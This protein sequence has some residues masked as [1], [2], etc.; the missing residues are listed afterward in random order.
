MIRIFILALVLISQIATAQYS[1]ELDISTKYKTFSKN[2]TIAI[3]YNDEVYDSTIK[4]MMAKHWTLSPYDF[5]YENELTSNLFNHHYNFIMFLNPKDKNK[6]TFECLALVQGGEASPEAYSFDKLLAYH[7]IDVK[8]SEKNKF[9][10]A[11]RLNIMLKS[12]QNTLT[13]MKTNNMKEPDLFALHKKTDAKYSSSFVSKYD[14][15]YVNRAMTGDL[16]ENGTIIEFKRMKFFFLDQEEFEEKV[17]EMHLNN[18]PNKNFIF[19]FSNSGLKY[20]QIYTGNGALVYTERYY[21]DKVPTLTFK[22]L[23]DIYK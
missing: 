21:F 17:R 15:T 5:M 1:S 6:V 16:T 9:S 10:C 18:K 3:L 19:A 12:M 14:T 11:Y 2:K 20:V 22:N 7:P 13:W 8:T 23:Q 4:A